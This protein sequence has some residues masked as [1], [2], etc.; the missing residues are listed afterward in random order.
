MFYK[1]IFIVLLI[2]NFLEAKEPTLAILRNVY[3][4]DFQQFTYKNYS[5]ICRPYGIA[6]LEDVYRS[7]SVS[8][9]CKE[10]IDKFYIQNPLLKHLSASLLKIFQMY[11][12]TFKDGKCLIHAKG[13][14]TLSEILVD[15]GIAVKE[16]YLKDEIY[17]YKLDKAQKKASFLKKG[18]HKDKVLRNCMIF[19]RGD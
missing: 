17:G 11:H 4:N 18:L 16:K 6:T 5:F 9:V 3:S 7:P 12:I 15:N 1:F 14:K 2:T 13:L 10:H 19:Y 8:S